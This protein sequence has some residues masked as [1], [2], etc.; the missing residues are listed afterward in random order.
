MS[1]KRLTPVFI[2]GTDT[3]VG[4]TIV[5]GML[6]KYFLNKGVNV[7]TQKW[8]QTG[9][10]DRNS[11][12]VKTHLNI[13]GKAS[14]ILP[15]QLPYCFKAACSP[16]LAAN[17]ENARI[18]IEKIKADFEYLVQNFDSVIAE[19][20]G[21]V[22]VPFTENNLAMDLVVRLKLPAVVVVQNKLGAVNH[23]LLTLEYLKVR[24][25]KVIGVIFNNAQDVDVDILEDNPKIIH[26]ISNIPTLGALP[27]EKD[28]AVLEKSFDPI[29]GKI[30]TALLR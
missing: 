28:L 11:S 16:H 22:Y 25:V 2:T 30:W 9:C 8:V 14:E 5:T 17:K 23:T 20:A 12:D 1:S 18:N 15:Q 10:L 4:K 21:G 27:F 29:A 3:D 13:M 19:G 24:K 6:A 26:A 7:I